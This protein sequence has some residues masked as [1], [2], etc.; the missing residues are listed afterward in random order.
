MSAGFADLNQQ[1]SEDYRKDSETESFLARMNRALVPVERSLYR[2]IEPRRPFVFVFGIPRSGTTLLS[3]LLAHCLELGYVDNLAARF[4][5]AP[6]CG[7]KLSRAVFD[8]DSF[9]GFRSDYG[10]TTDPRDIHEFGYFWM[11][12]LQKKDFEDVRDAGEREEEIDWSG[13]RRVLANL[14]EELGQGLV[15]KNIYGSYH[16]PRLSRELRDV[17]WLRTRR[18]ELDAAVSI[19]DARR[20][21]Y[22]DPSRWWSYVPPDYEK[23][24]DAGPYEQ[25]AGQIYYLRRFWA[26]ESDHP[27]VQGRVIEIEYD[28]MCRSPR[29][30]LEKVQQALSRHFGEE[31]GVERPPPE[32]FEPSVHDD[33]REDKARF[34]ALLQRIGEG[35][36]NG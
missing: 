25:I 29:A 9:A 18:D 1:R 15:A 5:L 13:L 14:Q 16:M 8:C 24:I 11:H 10:S 22:D 12:W 21:Y 34:R 30:V 31:I 35:R 3:Q 33:R 23:V 36:P 26:G 32:G 17:L 4:W 2:G 27:D 20:N 6:L 19:L 7:L 28:Q